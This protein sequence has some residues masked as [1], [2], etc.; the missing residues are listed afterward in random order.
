MC[1]KIHRRVSA[2]IVFSVYILLYFQEQESLFQT[3][4]TDFFKLSK[5]ILFGHR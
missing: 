1:Q 2:I 5:A 3:S 4:Y